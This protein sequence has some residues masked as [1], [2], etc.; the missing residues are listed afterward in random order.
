MKQL[1][2]FDLSIVIPLCGW[3]DGFKRVFSSESNYYE[4][5]GIEVVVVINEPSEKEKILDYIRTYPFINWKIV[6]NTQYHSQQNPAKAFNTGIRQA[7]KQYVLI[8]NPEL[9]FYTDMIYQLREKLDSYPEH[10]AICQVRYMDKLLPYENIMAKKEYFEKVGGYSEHYTE[11]EE[12]N[13]NICRR[14]ELAGIHRLLFPEIEL[15]LREN[16]SQQTV[17]KNKQQARIPNELLSEMLLPVD[18]KINKSFKITDYDTV[19]YDWKEHPYAKQQCRDYLST[20]KQFDLLSD[21]IFEKSYPLIALIPTYNE[22]E[23]ITDCL[24][25]VEKYCDGIILLDDEST[26]DTY[27]IAQSDKLLI[28]A[29][30]ARTEFN[31]KQNRNILLDIA[32]F[33]KA[34]WFIFIDA[35]ERFDD[36]FV[37]LR[38]VMKRDDVDA[39]GVWI[40][41]LWDS[42]ETYRTN[43]LDSH[44]L[45]QNGLWFRWRMF[46]NK[47][48]MQ[49]LSEN[50]LHFDS[51]PYLENRH[52]S[53][54]LL[55]HTGYLTLNKRNQKFSFYMNEDKQN[56]PYYNDILFK[57][58]KI[59]DLNTLASLKHEKDS[60]L[61]KNNHQ[62]SHLYLK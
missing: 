24:R 15:S 30:K 9:E 41:N 44:P 58:I 23:R 50:K 33:F 31:D 42:M 6:V 5:N 35:D 37:D 22:S 53:Q 25:S 38:E 43:M 34:E 3:F 32:S 49:I 14:L 8:M 12:E 45:S 18:I 4:R 61:K 54:T 13:N 40:A 16:S 26:D 17:S 56:K 62:K 29:K 11:W 2:D 59:Q 36:R 39:V 1:Q 46:R 57:T 28:K 7:T 20:L 21:D 55:L 60:C 52:I 51:V 10:Y 47:G 19:I 48:H 27:R